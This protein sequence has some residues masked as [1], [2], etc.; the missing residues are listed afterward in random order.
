M[1]IMDLYARLSSTP[2]LL[3]NWYRAGHRTLPWRESPTLYHVSISEIML[4]QTRV[5]AVIP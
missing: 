1:D 5:Q 2:H 4:Q 3:V